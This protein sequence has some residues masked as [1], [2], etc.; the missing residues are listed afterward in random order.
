MTETLADLTTE[1]EL[2]RDSSA[3][4]NDSHFKD[5]E[6]SNEEVLKLI[7]FS[8]MLVCFWWNKSKSHFCLCFKY[9]NKF[10]MFKYL[11][12]VLKSLKIPIVWLH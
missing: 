7:K 9:E 11:Y 10:K 4:D 1:E 8:L 5:A 3:C 12:Q 2:E 6:S